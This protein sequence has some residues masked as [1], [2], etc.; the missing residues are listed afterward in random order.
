MRIYVWVS[1][2]QGTLLE[3]YSS[4]HSLAEARRHIEKTYGCEVV[5]WEYHIA[6]E[7]EYTTYEYWE[8]RGGMRIIVSELKG[9]E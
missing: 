4:F 5:P 3:V 1:M 2:D 9:A 6:G 7:D 8:Y